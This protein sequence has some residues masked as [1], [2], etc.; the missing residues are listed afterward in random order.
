MDTRN[1]VNTM[2]DSQANSNQDTSRLKLAKW[3]FSPLAGVTLGPWI[4]I[5]KRHGKDIPLRYWPRTVF[6]T[7]MA[8]L[9]SIVKL[10][11]PTGYLK[12]EYTVKKPVFIIGHH[13]SGTT[14]LWKLM[15]VDDQFIYPTVTETIFPSTM[16]T[17]ES[18]ATT[19]AKKLSPRKRPQDNVKSSSESPMGEEWALCA[20]T[21]LSTHMGRHF[22]Q[23]RDEFKK[24]LT[25]RDVSDDDKKA[26]K[27]ALDRFGR[28][29]L[30]K[31]GGGK[32]LLFKAPTHTAKIRLLLELYPDARFIHISRNPY[33]VFQSTVNME[34]KSLPMCAYQKL[35]LDELEVYILWRY[36]TM[37]RSFFEDLELIPDDQI[38]QIKY[39]D[40][41]EDRVSA[42]E[43][44][45][46]KLHL[47]DFNNVKPQLE[48]Y[49]QSIAGYQKNRYEPL[50]AP[51]RQRINEH[52]GLIIEELGYDRH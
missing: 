47:G 39:E 18:I 27:Q 25:L 15:S 20:S 13:R 41:I 6:T 29:L 10:K 42:I 36:K 21:F 2:A 24:F 5:L 33:R 51:K 49:V 16:L 26:W 22:P 3:L 31:S 14:H 19:W 48:S 7:S 23:K 50:P 45:Y 28:K 12:E 17:F 40:L 43:S 52:W 37:Y 30:Y 35:N 32:T 9:N 46:D 1:G 8:A 38:T 11:E 4:N 44:I 34:L